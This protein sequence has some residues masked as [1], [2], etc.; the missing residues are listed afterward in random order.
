MRRVNTIGLP[1]N[2]IAATTVAAEQLW[3]HIGSRPFSASAVGLLA[4]LVWM[5]ERSSSILS[6]LCS[7]LV[8]QYM[9]IN[10]YTDTVINRDLVCDYA[11]KVLSLGLLYEE[12]VDAIRE[13]DG[14]R[15]MRRWRY[16][17][18]VFRE[19]VVPTTP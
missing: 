14:S 2:C 3:Y 1:F 9:H 18:L 6:T 5:L 17:L 11:S 15:V 4:R 12:F 8:D 19:M 16:L 13:G 10:S 7:L